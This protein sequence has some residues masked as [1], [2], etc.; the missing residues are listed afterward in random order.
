MRAD[1]S[2]GRRRA[3]DSQYRI[4]SSAR[5]EPVPRLRRFLAGLCGRLDV[6][7]SNELGSIGQF[8]WNGAATTTVIIDPQERLVALGVRSA[9]AVHTE[10]DLFWNF[11]TL[12]Y[13]ALVE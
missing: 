2:G 7:K 9:H 6:A 3:D 5:D 8:G 10:T 12:V 11:K 4:P 1:P 13:Q